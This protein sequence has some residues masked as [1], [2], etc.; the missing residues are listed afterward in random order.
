MDFL[1]QCEFIFLQAPGAVSLFFPKTVNDSLLQKNV[2]SKSKLFLFVI[3][4]KQQLQD[5]FLLL[6]MTS[7]GR[8]LAA[9]DK[10]LCAC[11]VFTTRN[12]KFCV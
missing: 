11:R 7:C 9:H 10:I 12:I 4:L 6:E 3:Y 5:L 1:Q 8:H 2:K